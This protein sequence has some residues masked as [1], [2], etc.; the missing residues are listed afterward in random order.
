MED[1]FLFSRLGDVSGLRLGTRATA[2]QGQQEQGQGGQQRT[3]HAHGQFL[4][5]TKAKMENEDLLL[6]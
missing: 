5:V 4:S 2:R 1:D 6:L 3:Q